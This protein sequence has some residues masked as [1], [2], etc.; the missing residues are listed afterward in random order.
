MPQNHCVCQR[1]AEIRRL[2]FLFK[3]L[4]SIGRLCL[5]YGYI[6]V[7]N[8]DI[9]LLSAFESN[10]KS[11]VHLRNF[12]WPHGLVVGSGGRGRLPRWSRVEVGFT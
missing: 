11:K 3:I 1:M 4:N 9:Q 6:F 12:G 8:Y 10:L 2:S 5:L 7:G